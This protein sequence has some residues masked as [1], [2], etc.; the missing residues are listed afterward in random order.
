MSIS[1]LQVNNQRNNQAEREMIEKLHIEN[2]YIHFN[3]KQIDGIDYQVV[4]FKFERRELK[5]DVLGLV[6]DRG[7]FLKEFLKSSINFTNGI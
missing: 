7:K 3:G 1:Y 4:V 2:L 6:D 5:L